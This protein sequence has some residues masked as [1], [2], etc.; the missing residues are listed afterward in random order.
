MEANRLQADFETLRQLV[1]DT[2]TTTTTTIPAVGLLPPDSMGENTSMISDWDFWQCLVED[3]PRA[4]AKLPHLVSAKLLHGGIPHPLRGVLWQAMAQSTSTRLELM[5]D[6]LV[7]NTT[8]P[9]PYAR[10]IQRDLSRTFPTV[11]MFKCDGGLGQQ[12]MERILT[13]YSI[14]DVQVGYCQGLAF[15]VGPLLM[16]VSPDCRGRGS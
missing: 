1:T 16:T 8:A 11:D 6:D 15:L 4:A 13:S 3:F 7:N 5:Y 9:S 2:T 10:V 12:A 14:Y